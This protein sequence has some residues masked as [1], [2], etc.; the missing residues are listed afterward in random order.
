MYLDTSPLPDVCFADIFPPVF[1]LSSCSLDIFFHGAVFNFKES[2]GGFFFSSMD[3][4]FGFVS[5]KLSPDPGRLDFLVFCSR[6]FIALHFTFRSVTH[7]DLSF[8]K[9]GGLSPHLGV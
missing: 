3:S 7:T 8:V 6:H 1:G 9:D 5:K 4:V 2:S